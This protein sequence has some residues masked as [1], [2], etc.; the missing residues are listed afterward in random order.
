MYGQQAKASPSTV[1]GASAIEAA[2]TRLAEVDSAIIDLEFWAGE[3]G[4][5]LD[6]LYG[7]LTPVLAPPSPVGCG[8]D[9]SGRGCILA[10]RIDGTIS[11][12]IGYQNL[13]REIEDRLDI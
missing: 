12:L 13:L 11:R 10:G 2:P 5:T 8:S 9:T 4:Q 3:V 1:L 6:R 7:R